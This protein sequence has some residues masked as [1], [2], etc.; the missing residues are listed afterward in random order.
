[1][2]RYIAH[3]HFHDTHILWLNFFQHVV[4][5]FAH[6]AKAKQTYIDL[7]LVHICF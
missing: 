3:A 6:G 4:E 7:L 2:L 1:M 5:A